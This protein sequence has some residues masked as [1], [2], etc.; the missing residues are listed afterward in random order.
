MAL[1]VL[2]DALEIGISRSLTLDFRRLPGTVID[3]P[4]RETETNKGNRTRPAAPSGGGGG[5][6]NE[7][8]LIF[9]NSGW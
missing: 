9:P 2:I 4:R 5:G 3:P 8:G 6:G 1:L 7:C